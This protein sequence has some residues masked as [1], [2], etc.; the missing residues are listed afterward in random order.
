MTTGK[1][2]AMTIHAVVIG[3]HLPAG[4]AGAQAMD[5]DVRCFLV[6]HS[7]GIALVDTGTPGSTGAIA[8]ALTELGATWTDVTDVLLSHDHPDHVGSLDDVSA[9]AIV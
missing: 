9:Q 4:V 8:A 6:T 2:A 5:F 3:V 7:S 1:G